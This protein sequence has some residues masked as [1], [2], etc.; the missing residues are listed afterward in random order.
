MTTDSSPLRAVQHFIASQLGKV[1]GLPKSAEAS[2]GAAHWLTGNDRLSPVEQLEIYRQQFWLR[3]T[4][5]L[6]EDYPGV[7]GILGQQQWEALVES[8]LTSF[9]PNSWTLRNLG[10]RFARHIAE[11][12]ETPHQQLC[13]D[14]ARL[15]W[16]YTELFDAPEPNRLDPNRLRAI[17]DDEWEHARLTLSP[18]L[19]L[20]QT[21][22]PVAPLR[23]RLRQ[24]AS[25]ELDQAIGIPEASPQHLVLFRSTDR[26]LRYD[27]LDPSAFALLQALQ[28]GWALL[29]ACESAAE[30]VPGSEERIASRVGDWFATWG[31]RGWIVD[32]TC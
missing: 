10:D 28:G 1:Q 22:F 15:E 20:L 4:N 5:S 8:Y 14:M 13:T 2:A 12:P 7:S 3:H 23:R 21:S 11:R 18:A 24:A 27:D 17:G 6:V 26:T 31:S 9:P 25:G 32:V 29:E 30:Q 19:R 16:L